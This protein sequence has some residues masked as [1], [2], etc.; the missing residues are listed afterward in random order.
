MKQYIISLDIGTQGTKCILFDTDMN[1]AAD[2]FE[3]SVLISPKPGVVWQEADAIYGSCVRTIKEVMEKSGAK[4]ADVCAIGID[5]QSAGIMGIDA[6]GEASTYYDSW[7]DMRCGKYMHEMQEKAGKRII[8]ICG[9]PASYTHGPK[10][11]WWKNEQPEAY[12]KTAKFVLPSGYVVNKMCGLKG[13]EA[14]FTHTCVHFSNFGDN[15]KKEWSDELLDLFGVAKDKMA[16]IAS[17]F[18]V[19]GKTSAAF[20]RLCGL[21]EGIPVVVGAGDTA[22]GAFG[23][24]MIHA[25]MLMDTAGTASVLCCASNEY[26]PDVECETLVQMPSPVEGLWHPLAYINGGGLCVRW[27]RDEFTGKPSA[28]YDTLMKEAND[29]PAGSEGIL[30]VPHFGGRV[31]PNNPYVKGSFIGLDW[32]HGR[33]HMYR[34]IME[35]IAYEYA[36]YF[37]ILKKEHSSTKF[38]KLYTT[39]GGSKSALMNS[40]KADVLGI[41]V[42]AYEQGETA[43][44]GSAIIAGCG[45]GVFS[46]YK[47]PMKN[48]G[49]EGDVFEPNMENHEKYKKYAEQYLNLIDALVPIYKSDVYDIEG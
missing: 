28:S 7:L 5:G 20:A 25:G 32:K 36:Y 6:E 35:G 40:I 2:A 30:F 11:L 33:G 49:N 34:A 1:M 17:S 23:S 21:M 4:A 48:L 46:D 37:S 3:V 41:P 12:A 45:A 13:A 22:A 27:F 29:I 15:V 9:G 26:H 44:T 47:E 19:A 24:G 43:L 18:D 8:E 38:E 16:R 42:V 39:G 31:L 10:I 14:T